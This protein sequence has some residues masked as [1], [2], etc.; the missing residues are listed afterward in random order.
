[1]QAKRNQ[2][3]IPDAADIKTHITSFVVVIWVFI[4]ESIRTEESD[5]GFR[6]KGTDYDY[7]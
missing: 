5:N 2:W 1:M 3:G 6:I 4:Q 7:T